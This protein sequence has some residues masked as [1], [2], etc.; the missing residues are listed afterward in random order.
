MQRKSADHLKETWYIIRLKNMVFIIP[1]GEGDKGG[2]KVYLIV[3]PNMITNLENRVSSQ[4]KPNFYFGQC[5][6][7]DCGAK[8][9]LASGQGQLLAIVREV[10]AGFNSFVECLFILDSFPVYLTAN[11][12]VMK[13]LGFCHQN[14]IGSH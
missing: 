2:S 12:V 13:F 8:V 3:C 5:S 7:I 9:G 14:C 4:Q 10:L 11:G 6:N 1:R